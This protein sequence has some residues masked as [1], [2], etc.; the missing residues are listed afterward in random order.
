MF[1]LKCLIN[2]IKI[3]YNCKTNFINKNEPKTYSW[4]NEY[5]MAVPQTSRKPR[6]LKIDTLTHTKR[7]GP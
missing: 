2:I 3:F 6:R 1:G 5:L 7:L 4:L